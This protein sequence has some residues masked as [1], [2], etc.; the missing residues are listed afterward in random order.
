MQVDHIV[1]L[2]FHPV[3]QLPH[4]N[5]SVRINH[6]GTHTLLL[7]FDIQ[8]LEGCLQLLFDSLSFCF[9]RSFKQ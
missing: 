8:F 3:V 5:P 4:A 2:P 7:R 1:R 6:D 9:W